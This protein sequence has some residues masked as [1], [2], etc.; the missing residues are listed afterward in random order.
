MASPGDRSSEPLSS[1][2]GHCQTR[3]IGMF[4]ERDQLIEHAPPA[5]NR[6]FGGSLLA[7]PSLK[8]ARN[9]TASGRD[10]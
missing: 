2:I 6:P 10:D 8:Q 1:G 5:V 4:E 7:T 9:G 3:G